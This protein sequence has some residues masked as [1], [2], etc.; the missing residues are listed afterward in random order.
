MCHGMHVEVRGQTT[1]GSEG[2]NSDHQTW[3]QAFS[4]GWPFS[5]VSGR[6]YMARAL[7]CA[8][9]EDHSV[10]PVLSFHL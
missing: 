10:E 1:C 5:E 4:S 2:L 6:V 7:V 9:S 3:R 8:K